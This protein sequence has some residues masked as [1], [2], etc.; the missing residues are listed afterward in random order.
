MHNSLKFTGGPNIA[1]KIPRSKYAET[2][3]FYRDTLQLE[4]E[5]QPTSSGTVSRTHRVRFGNFYLWLD[6]VD[7]YSRSE[8]WLELHTS[9]VPQATEYLR[10][11]N[12]STVDELEKIPK[13]MHWIMDPAGVVLLLCKKNN[14]S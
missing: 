3:T 6:C 13:D 2:L 14:E 5:E 10:S 11:N 12:I 8:I 9:D 1:L 4:V 7:N